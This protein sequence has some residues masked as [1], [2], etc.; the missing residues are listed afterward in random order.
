MDHLVSLQIKSQSWTTKQTH[1]LRT[2]ISV[3]LNLGRPWF[4]QKSPQLDDLSKAGTN[5]WCIGI[6]LKKLSKVIASITTSPKRRKRRVSLSQEDHSVESGPVTPNQI[7]QVVRHCD[8][9][10][11]HGHLHLQPVT[12]P[13]PLPYQKQLKMPNR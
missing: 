3:T 4:V 8:R 11:Q 5:L 2:K 12:C 9:N 7:G 6:G 13:E 1:P 10:H